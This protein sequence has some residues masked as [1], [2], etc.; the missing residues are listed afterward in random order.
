MCELLDEIVHALV[1]LQD[2]GALNKL[3]D[4]ALRKG[5][6]VSD[7]VEKGLRNGL[8]QVGER[9]ESGEYFLAE[10]LFAASMM[11]D[12]MSLLTP[13]LDA[14][15]LEEKG[16]IAL[17]TVRGD[18]HDI[19]K[20][21]FKMLAQGAGF[22]VYDLGVDVEPNRFANV[23]REKRANVLGLSALLTT[24]TPEMRTVIEQLKQDSMRDEVRV[25]LGGNAV[26]EQ[27]GKEIDADGA[28]R[29]AV[30]GV[31]FCREWMR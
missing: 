6:P 10:L 19:G 17:G 20:N 24:S 21:I 28:A 27:F 5:I 8:S 4:E 30:H 3:I 22:R 23:V 31:S 7:I 29:D 13:Q 2:S 9:Y 11:S 18:I 16:S 1:D 15:G 25:L 26:T 12:A 14:K